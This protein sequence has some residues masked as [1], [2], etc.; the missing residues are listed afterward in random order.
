MLTLDFTRHVF[1]S[2]SLPSSVKRR[3]FPEV[4]VFTWVVPGKHQSVLHVYRAKLSLC[5]P[6]IMVTLVQSLRLE[7][8]RK[9]VLIYSPENAIFYRNLSLYLFI[10]INLISQYCLIHTSKSKNG[11]SY[12]F[13]TKCK[14]G[15]SYFFTTVQLLLTFHVNMHT[16]IHKM[17]KTL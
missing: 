4:A 8:Q 11:V 9:A 2:G 17:Q 16:N 1:L 10:S 6:P 5:A 15:V 14:N 12:F 7:N 13:T 3:I